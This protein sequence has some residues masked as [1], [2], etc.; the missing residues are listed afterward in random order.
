MKIKII[1]RELMA[2]LLTVDLVSVA[3][4]FKNGNVF[5]AIDFGTWRMPQ[6][7]FTLEDERG[8]LV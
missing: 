7:T 4:H 5:M 3:V 1:I 8:G 2:H 6:G